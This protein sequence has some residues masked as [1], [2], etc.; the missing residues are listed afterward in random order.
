MIERAKMQ[1]KKL[2]DKNINEIDLI[3]N[4][5]IKLK[6]EPYNKL[7]SMFTGP[8]R[9]KEIDKENAIIVINDKEVTVNKNRLI[10]IN[11]CN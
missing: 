1:N 2:Y 11:N 9:V 4:D 6:R 5:M 7:Q 3:P 10:K 8:L